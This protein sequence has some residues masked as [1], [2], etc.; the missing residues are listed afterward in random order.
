[1]KY[2]SVFD[3]IGPVMIGPSSSH[4]AGAVQIGRIARRI[5]GRQPAS[6][7]IHFYG[8]FAKTY[9]GHATD[10][11]V[12]GGILDYGTDDSRIQNALLLA[13]EAG[14]KITFFKEEEIPVH[15]NTVK[16]ILRS[17][18]AKLSITG[19]SV[20]GGVIKITELDGFALSLSGEAPAI[21]VFHRDAFGAVASTTR[22]LAQ[23]HVNISHMEVSRLHKGEMALMIIETDQPL[24]DKI[25]EELR[26][27]ENISRVIGLAL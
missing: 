9:R 7:E 12:V 5:F 2:R 20:G 14:V 3:M 23:H 10:V 22:I 11:A 27:Q 15:P 1:M 4:T 18:D 24:D 8:S 17:P 6:V 19:I 16:L 13:E 26:S 21:L 25:L